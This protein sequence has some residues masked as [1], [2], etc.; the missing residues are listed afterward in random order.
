MDKTANT[1]GHYDAYRKNG[2]LDKELILPI[3]LI[4]EGSLNNRIYNTNANSL[5]RR[6]VADVVYLDPP[7]N[8]RQYCDLYHL[9]ENISQ[10]EKP[11]VYGVAKKKWTE[12]F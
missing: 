4:Q 11:Q 6:I 10:W 7:Y 5:A 2:I 3:P 8:S 1:C 9:L 12:V